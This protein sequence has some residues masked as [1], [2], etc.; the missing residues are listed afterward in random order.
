MRSEKSPPPSP[1]RLSN[2][3]GSSTP[4][5]LTP[6]ATIDKVYPLEYDKEV[7]FALNIC[8][9]TKQ[10]LYTVTSS[11]VATE[12]LFTHFICDGTPCLPD[13]GN[14][15]CS[16]N[17]PQPVGKCITSLNSRPEQ[18][19]VTVHASGGAFNTTTR[20]YVGSFKFGASFKQLTP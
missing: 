10:P 15:L 2:S 16:E 14:L 17:T 12:G 8:L 6:V 11:I 5:P 1:A 20:T 4:I 3:A 18:M 7:T 9:N 13:G 19:Y